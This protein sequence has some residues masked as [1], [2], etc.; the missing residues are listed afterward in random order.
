[1]LDAATT[2]GRGRQ[3]VLFVGPLPQPITG[4][5]LACQVFLDELRRHHAV[6]VVNLSKPSLRNGIDSVKRIVQVFKILF[7]VW[8]RQRAADVIYF[9]V[10]E[11][12]AGNIKDLVIYLLCF[13]RLRRMVIHLHGGAGLRRVLLDSRGWQRRVNEFFLRRVGGAIVLGQRH[14][15][16]FMHAIPAERIHMVPNFAQDYLFSDPQSIA[17]KFRHTRPLR[18]VYVSNLIPGKGYLE[19][20]EAFLSLNSGMRES[21]ALDLAGAFESP[22]QK[23]PFLERIADAPQIAYHG[24]VQGDRKRDLFHSAHVFCL[25]TYFPFEGQPISILEAYAAGCAVITTDHSGIG[26][27]FKD[28]A[29]GYEVAKRSAA[30]IKDALERAVRDPARLEAM[31]KRN[32]EQARQHYRTDLYNARLMRILETVGSRN[33]CSVLGRAGA[34][35]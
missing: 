28:G 33:G 20:I 31:A 17:R 26:D 25:P 18:I 15:D 2:T 12:F 10:S 29:N 6:E 34:H 1:M 3:K 8:R 5:S 14:V 19:L 7:G 23:R 11:S 24:V 22:E 32:L 27:V 16:V 4:H 30:S 9:T 21:L 35:E 13:R